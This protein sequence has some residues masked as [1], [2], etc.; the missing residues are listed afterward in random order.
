MRPSSPGKGS[1]T[2]PASPT[3]SCTAPTTELPAKSRGDGQGRC[4]RGGERRRD[5]PGVRQV[6]RLKAQLLGMDAAHDP[7][8]V[9]AGAARACDVGAKT[10]AHGKNALAV[11]DPEERKAPRIDL[12]KRLAMPA[13]A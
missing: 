4:A 1:N 7:D 2:P 9:D 13:H 5:A 3:P 8:T 6:A 11:G 10:V 12:G